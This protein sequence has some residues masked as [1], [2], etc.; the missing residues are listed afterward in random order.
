MQY[1]CHKLLSI[2]EKK[3]IGFRECFILFAE[4]YSLFSFVSTNK[5]A[6]CNICFHLPFKKIQI[7]RTTLDSKLSQIFSG[8][9]F[10]A[11][12]WRICQISSVLQLNTWVYQTYYLVQFQYNWVKFTEC[13]GSFSFRWNCQCH[14]LSVWQD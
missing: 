10:F 9:Y 8:L 3:N 6:M 13:I 1:G 12:M 5:D 7:E 14:A 4:K 2:T 11:Q